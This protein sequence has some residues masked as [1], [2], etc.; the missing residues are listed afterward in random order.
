MSPTASWGPIRS[1]LCLSPLLIFVPWYSVRQYY[2]DGNPH[3]L[4]SLYPSP[5]YFSLA[6][7]EPLT[8]L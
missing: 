1:L 8:E 3:N 6:L 5:N 4:P 2:H 7:P